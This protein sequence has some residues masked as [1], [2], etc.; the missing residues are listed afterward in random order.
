MNATY[1]SIIDLVRKR[2]DECLVKSGKVVDIGVK[3]QWL[4]E[5]DISI[6]REL[7]ALIN[8]FGDDY[9]IYGEEEN[10]VST[11]H[12][13]VWVIDPISSTFN[14][15]HGLPHFSI[16]LTHVVHG[17]PVFA[18]VYDP[19]M[20]ELFVAERGRGATVNGDPISINPEIKD[21]AILYDPNTRKLH[22]K[23]NNIALWN[24]LSEI[25]TIKTIGSFAVQY[26]YVACGRA[27]VAVS[28]NKDTFPEFAG[29]LLIEEAGGQFTD[30]SGG[31]L[32][33]ETRGVVGTNGILHD[34]LLEIVGKYT[35]D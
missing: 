30:F 34:R 28:R 1:Q 24:E 10:F 27:Q 3:K 22:K 2:G 33:M 12:H 26:A 31:L 9:A 4:T 11:K 13:N 32:T 16:V 15:I 20:K 19:S 21:I 18:V 35:K 17:D 23:N 5:E 7:V 25:G 29:K 6:E 14:F 8:S